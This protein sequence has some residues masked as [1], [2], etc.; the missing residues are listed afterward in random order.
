[1]S[2]LYQM[3]MHQAQ[4]ND[5]VMMLFYVLCTY[6]YVLLRTICKFTSLNPKFI[7][8]E[9]YSDQAIDQDGSFHAMKRATHITTCA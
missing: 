4:K 1:M 2:T 5:H 8:H 3:E 6:S 9:L 7:R